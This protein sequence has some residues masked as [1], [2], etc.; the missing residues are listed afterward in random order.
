MLFRSDEAMCMKHSETAYVSVTSEKLPNGKQRCRFEEML[1]CKTP[2]IP[3]FIKM[4]KN[5]NIYLDFTLSM[6]G[7]RAKDH[8]FLWRVPQE[9]VGD[10][11]AETRLI[12][13]VV[14]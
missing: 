11:Y 6:V 5:G 1:Y 9:A 8:G 3:K 2:S 12:D 14:G 7:D 10:L 13:L 4:A